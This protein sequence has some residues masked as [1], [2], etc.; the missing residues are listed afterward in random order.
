MQE[1]KSLSAIDLRG[2]VEIIA[3]YFNVAINNILYNRAIYPE[4][5]FKRVKKFGRSVLI[6]TDEELIKY[7]DKL[8]DQLKV[9]L[10]A[11]SLKRLVIV[12]K[13]VKSGAILERWQFNIKREEEEVAVEDVDEGLGA[14]VRQIVASTSFLPNIKETCTFDLLVYTNRNCEI[15]EGWDESGPCFVP[16]SAQV[17]LRSFSTKIHQVESIVSYRQK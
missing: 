12:I 2:S 15:P 9:W 1:I 14:I 11:D 16:N 5:S 10:M 17:Q 6:T 4:S 3:D 7:L 13:S 8:I